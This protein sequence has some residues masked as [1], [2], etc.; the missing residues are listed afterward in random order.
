MSKELFPPHVVGNVIA[1]SLDVSCELGNVTQAE[2]SL[3]REAEIPVARYREEMLFLAGFAQDFGI[4]TL[5]SDPHVRD[6]V[7]RGYRGLIEG[8]GDQYKN[9]AGE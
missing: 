5:I 3:L 9:Q 8:R 1:Q 2:R 6:E 7:L 4:S